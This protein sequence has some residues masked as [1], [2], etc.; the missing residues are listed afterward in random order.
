MIKL[1][2]LLL[3]RTDLQYVASE[4]VKA[5]GLKSKI[6]GKKIQDI[7]RLCQASELFTLKEF[8]FRK[9]THMIPGEYCEDA[10]QYN[11]HIDKF[12]PNYKI[13]FYPFDIEELQ[14]PT[15]LYRGSQKHTIEKLKWYHETSL[16]SR[17]EKESGAWSRLHL[18]VTD[19]QA[20]AKKLGFGDEVICLS[21]IHI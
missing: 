7:C 14:G 5:H 4:L 11:Y 15:G 17:E 16:L 19:H 13:W 2:Y 10:R 6:R 21:L 1:K 9:I 12:Y 20:P 8:Y 18:N 3:E